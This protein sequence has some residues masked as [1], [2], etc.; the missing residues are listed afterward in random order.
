[1]SEEVAPGALH[2]AEFLD[3]HVIV[4]RTSAGEA[5]V[6]SPYCRHYGADLADGDMEDGCLIRCP[7]HHWKYDVSGQCVETA[8]GDRV[9]P[10]TTLFKFP[11]KEKWGLIWAFNGLHPTY[12]VPSWEEAEEDRHFTVFIAADYP[13]DPFLA[14]MNVIDTQH[15]RALHGL[16][17][18]DLELHSDGSSF[19]ADMTVSGAYLGLPETMRHVEL[20]GTNAMVYSKASTGIDMLAAATPYGGGRSRLYIVTGGLRTA[21]DPS[22]IEQQVAKRQHATAVVLQ[23]DLPILNHIRFRP[24]RATKSDRAN[25]EF[26]R[27]AAA[28]PRA[29]PSRDFIT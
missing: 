10:D 26:L 21:Y 28:Y 19:H 14:T 20:I 15:L 4:V 8:V 11:T 2:R 9:P 16:D 25:H 27:S 29:H 18:E 23:Q 7:F 24:E 17:V 13:G 22:E 3:G 6:L 5:S 12:E 1:M